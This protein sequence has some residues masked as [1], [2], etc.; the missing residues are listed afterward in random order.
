MAHT[1]E[2]VTLI[3]SKYNSRKSY[4]QLMFE[5]E[6]MR[7]LIVP[8]LVQVGSMNP[9]RWQHIAEVFSTVGLLEAAPSLEGFMYVSQ[10]QRT[11]QRLDRWGPYLYAM[12]VII[13]L[14]AIA[15]LLFN[16]K[17]Q[18]G[19]RVQTAELDRNRQ[20]LRQVLDLVPSMVYAKNAEGRLLLVNQAEIGRA[21]V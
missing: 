10:R 19:I 3:R 9:K 16:R 11:L 17:L 8:K 1:E 12:G 15:L 20:N 2:I 18:K 13:I 6:A 21:H 5:A 7:E 4:P 14:A